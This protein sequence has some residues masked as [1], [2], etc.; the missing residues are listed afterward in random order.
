MTVVAGFC[1]CSA[2]NQQAGAGMAQVNGPGKGGENAQSPGD[3]AEM[4]RKNSASEEVVDGWMIPGI[5]FAQYC[6]R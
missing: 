2:V 1:V 4:A 3:F 5:V 6:I